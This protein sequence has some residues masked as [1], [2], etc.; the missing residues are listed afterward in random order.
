M[1]SR[2][3]SKSIGPT[4]IFR[5]L[6]VD[7]S[8]F[9]DCFGAGLCGDLDLSTAFKR[10]LAVVAVDT[11]C[12]GR[13]LRSG[14]DN[15]GGGAATYAVRRVLLFG[16]TRPRGA[17]FRPGVACVGVFARVGV[18][19]RL[20]GV[21]VRVVLLAGA[22]RLKVDGE[23]ALE[24]SRVDGG[25]FE[26]LELANFRTE[27]GSRDVGDAARSNCST[28]AIGRDARAFLTKGAPAFDAATSL[29][30]RT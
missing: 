22:G 4:E 6:V 11:D 10:E 23:L 20:T 25:L 27:T 26:S 12:R 16:V 2:R 24:L 1:C 29:C 30:A 9:R 5:L 8:G 17:G 28:S 18:L 15:F 7:P 3:C 14:G 13:E 19:A 21:V